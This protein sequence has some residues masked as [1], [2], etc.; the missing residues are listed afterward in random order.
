MKKKELTKL[1]LAAGAVALLAGCTEAEGSAQPAGQEGAPAEVAVATTEEAAPEAGVTEVPEAE[2]TE[3]LAEEAEPTEAEEVVDEGASPLLLWDYE[4]YVDECEGYI[5]Q[6]EFADR[7][8]DGDGTTDRLKRI[9]D[10]DAEI[11]L[12]TIEF[13]NGRT[14]EVPQGWNTGFP[15]VQAEDLDGDG[16]KEILFT[17]T[18]D[19]STDPKSFGDLWLFDYDETAAAYQE[20]ELP[21]KSG[22]NGARVLSVD[23]DKPQDGVVTIH[24]PQFDFTADCKVGDDFSA[25]EAYSEDRMVFDAQMKDGAISC[26]VE[27]FAKQGG[28]LQF[29]LVWK[30]GTY[31]VEM[32]GMYDYN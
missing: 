10:V 16:E 31:E 7:D 4:G 1:L 12:Y 17:L 29:D 15:H 25:D 18:Y 19:T 2:V 21:L 23:Y 9:C 3:A 28:I 20:V 11:A 13:G 6:S 26:A 22:E 30:N 24:V 27:L 8:I 5:W 32:K 14:L